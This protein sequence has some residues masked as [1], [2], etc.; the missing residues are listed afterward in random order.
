MT[1]RTRT[2]T[3]A[4]LFFLSGASGLVYETAWS[5]LFQDLF[6][7]TVHTNAAVLAAFMAGL[8]LGAAVAGRFAA[9]LGRPILVYGYLELLIAAVVWTS[10]AQV[11]L[12]DALLPSVMDGLWLTPVAGPAVRWSLAFLLVLVPTSLMGATLPLLCQG[13]TARTADIGRIFG[14]LYGINTLGAVVGVVA[15]G[16]WL[17]RHLGVVGTIRAGCGLGFLAAVGAIT[18]SRMG[19]EGAGKGAFSVGW[20]DDEGDRANRRTVPLPL[21]AVVFFSGLTALAYEVVW[22]RTFVFILDSNILSFSMVLGTLLLALGVG[23]IVFPRA[24]RQRE[25]HLP[26]LAWIQ[27]GLGLL[28]GLTVLLFVHFDELVRLLAAL[29]RVENPLASALGRS[30]ITAAVVFPP[31]L[32]MG[33]VLP[34]ATGILRSHRRCGRGIGQLYG[35]NTGGNIAG[36]LLAGYLFIPWLGTSRTLVLMAAV[37]ILLGTAILLNLARRR[38]TVAVTAAA[39]C[40]A[41]VAWLWAIATPQVARE[42]AARRNPHAELILMREALRGTVTVYDVPPIPI[43]AANTSRPAVT[44]V[45]LGYRLIAV[46]GIDVAGTSPDLRT[47]QKMQAHIPLLLHGP[48]RRVLQIGYGSGETTLEALRHG[49]EEY[50]LV[51]INPDVVREANRWFPGF[52]SH[53]F[54][55]FFTDAKNYVRTTSTR[56]DVILNDS[57]YPGISGSSL[58]YSQDHFRACRDRLTDSGVLSTWLPIDLPAERFRMVLATF[59]RVFPS[60]SFWLPTNCWNKHGV[61]VGSVGAHDPLLEAV[62]HGNWPEAV[63]A[64]LGEIG[65][66]DPQL[67]ASIRVLDATDIR[68]LSDGVPTNSDDRPYLEYPMQG[69]Q[70]ASESFWSDTLR[71]ILQ[72]HEQGAAGAIPN[73]QQAVQNILKGQ[74]ALL[75]DNP[76]EALRL[77]GMA[78]RLAPN[79]PGPAILIQDIQTFRAQATFSEAGRLLEKGDREGALELLRHAAGLCPDSAVVRLETGR[80]ELQQGHASRAVTHLEACRKLTDRFPRAKLMLGDAYLLTSRFD[81][82]EAEY[83]R[84]LEDN[85]P[86]FEILAALADAVARSGRPAEAIPIL[87]HAIRLSP[88]NETAHSMLRDLE[89]R[90]A[91]GDR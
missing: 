83:R 17:I 84:Y 87:E 34:A 5:R 6:G 3:A 35:A 24:L 44:P 16:Y 37:N 47:T 15:A 26:A 41:A 33:M 78:R 4:I 19:S 30:A 54:R 9:R 82:A 32:L 38:R 63:T 59:S 43:L 56:Y 81:E 80:A 74:L 28:S 58:L 45:A 65:Y 50:H 53:G 23:S 62:R 21:L 91:A 70:V 75:N 2:L 10:P 8:G 36:S 71:L 25:R 66:G 1:E 55:A 60:C 18:L 61:L 13:L 40:F 85:P 27:L 73:Q 31:G 86:Q 64:S 89:R 67:F 49:P 77:Y 90:A 29:G 39:A 42:I 11:R 20:R 88:A 46:N 7:H 57:T 72:R 76:D 69:M 14:G 51:E 52:A 68:A 12:V 48:A 22:I 79:H